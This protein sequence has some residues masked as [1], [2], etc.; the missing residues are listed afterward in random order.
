MEEKILEILRGRFNL[1]HSECIL[2]MIFNDEIDIYSF[3]SEVSKI[4]EAEK[5]DID[6]YNKPG[7]C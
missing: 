3:R 4:I 5:N 2:G 7:D 1:Y 6:E